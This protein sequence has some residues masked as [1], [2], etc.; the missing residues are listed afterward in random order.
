MG[1]SEAPGGGEGYQFLLKI[2]GEG[3]GFRGEG[4][5]GPGGCLQRIGEFGGAEGG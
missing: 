3:G 1:Q 5:E 2:P 4:A